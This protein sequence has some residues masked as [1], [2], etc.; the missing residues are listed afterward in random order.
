[1]NRITRRTFVGSLGAAATMPAF[2]A[3]PRRPRRADHHKGYP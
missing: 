1:M 2:S 3:E